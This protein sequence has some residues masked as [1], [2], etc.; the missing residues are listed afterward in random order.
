MRDR[1]RVREQ[2]ALTTS[3][4]ARWLVMGGLLGIIC[5]GVLVALLWSAAPG[6]AIGGL[7]AVVVFYAA[8]VIARLAIG[9]GRRRLAVMA[10]G[11]GCLAASALVCVLIIA[12]A[13]RVAT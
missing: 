13:S 12:G 6:V 1:T 11:M 8:M 10:I 3:G 9:P 2:A 5:A 7:I 4:G